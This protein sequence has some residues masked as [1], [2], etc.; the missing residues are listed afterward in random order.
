MIPNNKVPLANVNKRLAC[1]RS[2]LCYSLGMAPYRLLEHTA[3]IGL[4][5]SAASIEELFAEAA[6]GLLLLLGG[7]PPARPQLEQVVEVAAGDREELLVN[8][9]NELLFLL[10][11]RRFYLAECR[12]E[13][14]TPT[15]LRATLYGEALD[16]SRH[17]FA[18]D[19]KAVTHHR[20][21]LEEQNGTWQARVYVDL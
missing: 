8:W 2:A 11:T 4:L 7:A 5:A 17:T 18:R 21:L 3:D 6:R 1:Q 20:L 10:E 12:I 15:R 19:A 16:L 9:L 14:L 13:A